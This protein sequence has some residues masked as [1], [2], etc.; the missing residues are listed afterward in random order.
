MRT[1]LLTTA[2]GMAVAASAQLSIG[3]A[4][5]EWQYPGL[6]RA[7]MPL[8][9]LG[10]LV[11]E[12]EPVEGEFRYGTQRFT[13]V[14][15]LEEGR[16]DELPDGQR[17]CRLTLRSEGAV[18]LSAQF[19]RWELPLGASVYLYDAARLHFIGGFDRNNRGPDGTMATAVLPGDELVIEYRVPAAARFD[20]ELRLASVTHG[21][22]DL[23]NFFADGDAAR[24]Y[25]PG[26]ES[27]TCQ[28]NINCPQAAAWQ[29]E[30]RSVAM[31][32]RPDGNGCTGNLV[33]NTATPGRPFFHFAWHC[34]AATTPQWVFYFNYEAPACVGNMGNT[35]QTLTGATLRALWFHTDMGLVELNNTPPASYNAYYAG[36]DRSGAVPQTGAVIEHPMYDV[37]KFC[38]SDDGFSTFTY[39]PS[40]ITCWRGDW[41]VGLIQSVASGAP[42]FDQNHHMVGHLFD[43]AQVCTTMTTGLSDMAKFSAGWDGN[44]ASE[45]MR[46]WLDPSNTAMQLDG[47]DPNV[48]AVSLRVRAYL[49]GP[50]NT[51]TTQMNSS[52]RASGLIPLTEPYTAAGYTHVAGG[53]GET[54]NNGVL[55]ITGANAA[56]DWVVVELRNK[57][58]SAQ[59]LA[60]R[61][62]LL[63]ADGD[64]VAPGD[65]WSQ[66]RFT[67]PNDQYFVAVRHRNHLGIMTNAAVSLSATTVSL[68]LSNGSVA[69]YGGANAT[70]VAGT[71]NVLFAGDVDRNSIL[72]YTGASNDRD[73]ILARIGGSVPTTSVVGY[74]PEDVNMD[75]VVL[76]TG[77]GNDRD[78]I[79]VNVGGSIPTNTRNAQLP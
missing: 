30:K 35:S 75:G 53:G 52:L 78:P 10:P 57:N 45:R 55:S 62:A 2:L 34:Y 5:S 73:P 28:V 6:R 32:L 33:H 14:D 54:T 15:M 47:Y 43:G 44:Q 31:F 61:S 70:K 12:P 7:A 37:K 71:R 1:T 50:Y 40:N 58:N 38:Y 69:L 77:N 63:Q 68:D 11:Q 18:M 9:D 56:V 27:L 22:L 16:W 76:Y 23:F 17:I 39:T 59:V 8:V 46:D 66:L 36:W 4:P 41:E 26:F 79:L 72:R 21:F 67:V 24:D 29:K 42:M 64:I 49:E 74:W 51:G 48:Q 3:G 13:E 65:G 20:G 60:T 25:Y 19:D